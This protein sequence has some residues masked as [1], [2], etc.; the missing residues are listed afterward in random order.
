[1]ARDDILPGQTIV[2][3]RVGSGRHLARVVQPV[4]R[5]TECQ[6]IKDVD[7]NSLAEVGPPLQCQ[8]LERLGRKASVFEA[9]T[10]RVA[11]PRNTAHALELGPQARVRIVDNRKPRVTST[12]KAV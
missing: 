3:S 2:G 7:W 12:V 9:V 4:V 6:L 10:D 8:P 1:M 11:E 5:A